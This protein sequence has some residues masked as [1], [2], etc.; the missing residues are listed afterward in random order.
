[1]SSVVADVVGADGLDLHPAM[2]AKDV[3]GWD[4]LA[5]VTIM[6]ALERAFGI[7]FRIGELATVKNVGDL[8]GHIATRLAR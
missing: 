2:T 7:R 1:V 5:H 8:V 6:V 4:S 3:E